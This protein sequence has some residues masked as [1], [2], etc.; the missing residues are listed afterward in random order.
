MLLC[1]SAH[2]Y[3]VRGHPFQD[4]PAE[5]SVQDAEAANVDATATP[6]LPA[7][8]VSG[9]H[10]PSPSR[11][12]SNIPHECSANPRKQVRHLILAES[13]LPSQLLTYECFESFAREAMIVPLHA[14][15]A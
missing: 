4:S 13:S 6:I 14:V 10:A 1:H 3:R 15:A 7:L 11:E 9:R 2:P 8:S 12:S 5:V